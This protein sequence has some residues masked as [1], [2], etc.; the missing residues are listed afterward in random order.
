MDQERTA[1]AP[2]VL[3]EYDH[4]PGNYALMLSDSHMVT[5]ADAVFEANG[6]YGNGYGWADVAVGV[7]RDQAPELKAAM[8][9]DPE[10]GMFVAF[11]S[12]LPALQKLA[13]LLHATF[14]DHELLA[15]AVRA[16]PYE[17][18]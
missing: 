12:D 18:D 1:Y 11:G 3:F 6:R 10:A 2:F 9:I 16:A 5:G 15:A 7:M 13:G 17:Y 8:G 14:H 4:K